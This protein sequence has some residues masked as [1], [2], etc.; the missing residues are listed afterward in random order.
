MKGQWAGG[1]FAQV[2]AAGVVHV[3]DPIVW[4]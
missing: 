4:I 1:A 3:G 2:L